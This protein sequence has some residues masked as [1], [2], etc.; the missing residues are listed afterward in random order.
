MS[1][2]TRAIVSLALAQGHGH[3]VEDLGERSSYLML[4]VDRGHDEIQVLRRKPLGH[5]IERFILRCTEAHLAH[6]LLHRAA[7]RFYRFVRHLLEALEET[8]PRTHGAR[9]K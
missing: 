6:D 5:P 7:G 2:V 4:H 3:V 1:K 9:E 8:V